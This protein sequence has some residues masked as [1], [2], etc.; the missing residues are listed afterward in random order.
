MGPLLLLA[1]LSLAAVPGPATSAPHSADWGVDYKE[2]VQRVFDRLLRASGYDSPG[3][4]AK[5]KRQP[6]R[7]IYSDRFAQIE[8]SP[9][10]ACPA[11]MQPNDKDYSVVAAGYGLLEF[12]A[13]EDEL[14]FILG[15]ELAH[16]A[17]NHAQRLVDMKLELFDKWY[18]GQGDRVAS[19]DAQAVAAAF[20][21]END[22]KLKEL[23]R[24]LEREADADGLNLMTVAGFDR[25]AAA[26]SLRRAQDWL[27]AIGMKAPDDAHDP[28][29]VRAK[30][31][32]DW[33]A[34]QTLRESG[35][36]ALKKTGQRF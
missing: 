16:L 10:V 36:R 25:D 11:R 28:I 35:E 7:L 8:G 31:L 23:Q 3:W 2:K 34:S 29:W 26:T 12:V 27:W 5:E 14:A 22:G 20:A 18:D 17:G 30:Q 33:T 19:M 13:D 4:L 32:K 24:A 6:T 15:H 1:A 9:A 21:R